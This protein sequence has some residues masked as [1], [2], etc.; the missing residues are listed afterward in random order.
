ML[1]EASKM[2]H[3]GRTRKGG[4]NSWNV[5]KKMEHGRPVR[6]ETWSLVVS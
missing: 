3:G 4:G 5:N 2:E 6:L 1:R